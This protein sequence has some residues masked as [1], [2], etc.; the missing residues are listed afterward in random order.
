[1]ISKFSVQVTEAA[2]KIVRAD[3]VPL[4]AGTAV[5]ESEAHPGLPQEVHILRSKTQ[6]IT[7]VVSLRLKEIHILTDAE[8]RAAGVPASGD[9]RWFERN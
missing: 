9:D 6:G 8:A 1:M 4:I 7:V 3:E 5:R 2:Q